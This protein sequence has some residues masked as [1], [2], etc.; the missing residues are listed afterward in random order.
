M[1]AIAMITAILVLVPSMAGA[2]VTCERGGGGIPYCFVQAG[3]RGMF[4]LE[5]VCWRVIRCGER[6][7][8]DVERN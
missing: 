5:T 6:W 3:D 8:Y 2:Q 4:C 1:R 7:C